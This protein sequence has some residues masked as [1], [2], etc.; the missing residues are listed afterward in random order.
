MGEITYHEA[1]EGWLEDARFRGLSP[2]TMREYKRVSL[3]F[4]AFAGEQRT[5]AEVRASDVRRWLLDRPLKPASVAAYVRALRAFSRWC[6]REYGMAEPLAGLRPPRVEPTPIPVFAPEQLRALLE[7]APL[8]LAYAITLLTETGLRVSEAVAV[9]VHDMAG[10]WLRVRR[11]KGGRPRSV[12]VSAVLAEASR[13]YLARS[14]AVLAQAGCE[15]LL[16]N[17][18]G[19]AWTP[20][21]MRLALRRLGRRAH[22]EGVRVSPH[23]FR[24]QFAHDVAFTGGSL[25]ALRDVLGHRSVTMVERYAVPDDRA[26]E[27]L[28]RRRTPLHLLRSGR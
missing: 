4:G 6:A 22:I 8:H 24:H 23:T 10:D 18:R 15:R 11:G 25:I 17:T 7:A 21:A 28:V 26:R 20:D 9:E 2:Q 13:V 3:A 27:E 12:P 14:R 1:R 19:Q 5:L 16:V